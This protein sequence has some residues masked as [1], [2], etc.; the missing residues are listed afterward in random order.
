[1]QRKPRKSFWR[2][3]LLL[4]AEGADAD[5]ALIGDAGELVVAA[6]SEPQGAVARV[7]V[8]GRSGSEMRYLLLSRL[9]TSKALRT[10]WWRFTTPKGPHAHRLCA[11]ALNLT[12]VPPEVDRGWFEFPRAD[13][14]LVPD[15]QQE[16]GPETR[17][18]H[19]T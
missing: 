14:D 8:I 6:A 2:P 12:A 11:S 5:A 13:P 16:A 3:A 7:L 9:T 15:Q 17:F 10:H 19:V 1:M 18:T 4:H